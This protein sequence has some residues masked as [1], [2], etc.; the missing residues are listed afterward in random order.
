MLDF[1]D[2]ASPITIGDFSGLENIVGGALPNSFKK[3]YLK[4]NGG[5]LA[6]KNLYADDYIYSIHGFDSIKH[7]D[8]TIEQSYEDFVESYGELEGLVPFAFDE[9]GNNYMLSIRSSDYGRIY[10]WL[11]EEE[12]LRPVFESFDLFEK[13]L[14]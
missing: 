13:G 9:G 8:S 14:R 2:S 7:G 1:E 12:E 3:F 11:H 4:R 6:S 10:L 5:Y